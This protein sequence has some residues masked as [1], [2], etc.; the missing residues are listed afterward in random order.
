[1]SEVK[2][3]W[4]TKAGLNAVCLFVND[5]HHCGYVEVP[6]GHPLHGVDYSGESDSLCVDGNEPCGK[7]SPIALFILASKDS[8]PRSPEAA[9]DAHGGITFAGGSEKYPVESDR[10]GWWFGFDCAHLGDTC[11]GRDAFEFESDSTFKDVSYV[12]AECE[13]L[14]EQIVR[15]TLIQPEPKNDI[16]GKPAFCT[17][18]IS[19]LLG[20][21]VT[22]QL[23]EEVLKVPADQKTTTM[24]LWLA[25]KI[26]LICH[27]FSLHI[28][29]IGY[30]VSTGRKL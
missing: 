1:M 20:V 2:K 4:K 11:L 7:R 3:E 26:P 18:E 27:Q 6:K 28:Q 21:M 9:F 8:I 29:T 12:E 22:R 23:I 25:E 24:N 5:S 15:K 30:Q 13:S 19:S 10:E 16:A 17:T 14:A